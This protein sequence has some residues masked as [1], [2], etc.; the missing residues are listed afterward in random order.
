MYTHFFHKKEAD[1]LAS[2]YSVFIRKK[3]IHWDLHIV[4]FLKIV[5][6]LSNNPCADQLRQYR[7]TV[8]PNRSIL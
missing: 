7:R 5:F 8:K 2:T 4:F 3:Q 1:A 6:V